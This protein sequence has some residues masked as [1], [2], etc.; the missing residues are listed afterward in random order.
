MKK[1]VLGLVVVGAVIAGVALAVKKF[2]E[3]DSDFCD[4]D[5]EHCDGCDDC[6]DFD[7]FEDF[8]EEDEEDVS[9]ETNETTTKEE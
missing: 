7:D 8:D 3:D 9:S 4:G 2:Y 5:C 6:D 1:K